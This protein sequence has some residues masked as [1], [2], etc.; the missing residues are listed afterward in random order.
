MIKVK[1]ELSIED[2]ADYLANSDADKQAKFFN[3]FFKSMKLACET[4]YRFDMQKAHILDLLDENAR[5][6][7][8]FMRKE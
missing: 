4:E 8:D 5:E 2:I 7:V 3:I 1:T 6:S